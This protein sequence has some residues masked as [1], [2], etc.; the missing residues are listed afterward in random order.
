MTGAV[1]EVRKLTKAF[2]SLTVIN[3]VSLSLP[4]GGRHALIG[5]NGAGK[6]TLMALVAGLLAPDAGQVLL[7]GSDITSCPAA[8]RVKQG[9]VRSF[10]ISQLFPELMVVE[11]VCLALAERDGIG[12]SPFRRF[13][14]E[15]RLFSE[16]MDV[17]SQ[18]RLSDHA[19]EAASRLPYG[20]QRLLE[21]AIA[22]ALR[23]KVLLLDEPAAGVP[24]AD[25][26]II[27]DCVDRLPGDVAVLLIEHDMDL[28]FR[29][30]ERVTV[31]MAGEVIASGGPAAIA[32]DARVQAAYLGEVGHAI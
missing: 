1:L 15:R 13:A 28:V 6:T 25:T 10:Q 17:L 32:S 16:A 8:R 14:A 20:H 22:L 5:P 31:L 30:A 7:D 23:P 24:S 26:D 12:G 11:N 27:L 29:F 18:V 19:M 9:L 4:S 3:D 21:L 2:G